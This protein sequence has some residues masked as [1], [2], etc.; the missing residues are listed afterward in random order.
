[1]V[2]KIKIEMLKSKK[3]QH[4]GIFLNLYGNSVKINY[5]VI[6]CI[7]T[8]LNLVAAESWSMWEET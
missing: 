2:P 4:N 6:P 1:M 3:K 5:F 7:C 8:P